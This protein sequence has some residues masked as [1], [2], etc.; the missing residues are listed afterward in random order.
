[1]IDYATYLRIHHLS[2]HENL[3]HNQIAQHLEIHPD[4]VAKWLNTDH[5]KPRKVTPRLSKLDPFKP[6]ILRW[7]EHYPYTGAQIRQRLQNLGYDGG[8]TILNDYLRRVRPKPRPAY[9]KLKFDPGDSAQVDWGECGAIHIQGSKRKL[10]AFIMV[11]CYS[12][13]LYLRFYLSQSLENFLDGHLRAFSY[14]GGVPRRLIIDNLKTAVLEH[15]RGQPPEFHPRYLDLAR[16]YGFHPV[17]CNIAKGNEKGRVER[18]VGYVKDNFLGGRPI[19]DLA[20]LQAAAKQWR[21]QIANQRCHGVTKQTPR[22]H[23]EEQEKAILSPLRLEAYDCA[24]IRQA[25][26]SKDGRVQFETNFYSVPPGQSGKQLT[27]KIYADRIQI[28]PSPQAPAIAI[29]PRSYARHQDIEDRAH[30]KALKQQRQRAR[31][32][33]LSHDFRA[34]GAV[35]ISYYEQLKERHLDYRIQIRRLLALRDIYG[36][37]KLLRA[38]RDGLELDAVNAAYVEHLLSMRERLMPQA[39]PIHLTRNEDQLDLPAPHVDL[40]IYNQPRTPQAP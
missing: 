33:N 13:L 23:F 36:E 5:Y 11:L 1:M 32:Q 12:R 29:H 15:R 39:S 18:G 6:Q 34:L 31:E 8:A 35:A 30:T 40:D 4:T 7:I 10:H 22:K 21:D 24:V 16:H 25:R 28:H 3:N 9:L 37:E 2:R 27:L 26:L 19:A 20:S 14:F 38:L 17:A